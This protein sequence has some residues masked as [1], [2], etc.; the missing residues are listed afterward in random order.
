MFGYGIQIP[1]GFFVRS[2]YAILF[3]LVGVRERGKVGQKGSCGGLLGFERVRH[4]L[5]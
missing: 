2:A 5:K 4:M 1:L 3:A